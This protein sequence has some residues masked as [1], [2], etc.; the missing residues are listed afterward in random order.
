MVPRELRALLRIKVRS[1]PYLHYL[2][3]WHE[4][5]SVS[6]LL[7]VTWL[8]QKCIIFLGMLTSI[9]SRIP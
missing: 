9:N 8:M 7:L 6:T 2:S 4:E 5:E 1:Q 3:T